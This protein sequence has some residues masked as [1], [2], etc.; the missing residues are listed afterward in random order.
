MG[1]ASP[2]GI[3]VSDGD[4]SEGGILGAKDP[5]PFN[6]KWRVFYTQQHGDNTTVEIIPNPHVTEA[7]E[8]GEGGGIEG[9][10]RSAVGSALSASTGRR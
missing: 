9:A 5:R 4:A 1:P 2:T 7:V 8:E 10:M 6:G 3:H